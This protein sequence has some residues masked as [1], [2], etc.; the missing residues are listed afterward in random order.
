MT[1]TYSMYHT[2]QSCKV[3]KVKKKKISHKS[4]AISLYPHKIDREA[5]TDLQLSVCNL[6]SINVVDILDKM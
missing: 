6:T 3:R 1:I 5:Y 2:P 4:S